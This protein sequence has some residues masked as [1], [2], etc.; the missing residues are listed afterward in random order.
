MIIKN[1]FL[2]FITKLIS[3][4]LSFILIILLTRYLGDEQFGKYTQVQSL[5]LLIGS[6]LFLPLTASITRFFPIEENKNELL[7]NIY[8]LYGI[9]S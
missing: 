8:F 6:A 9:I 2:Y 5:S 1:S 3:A 4:I 7:R